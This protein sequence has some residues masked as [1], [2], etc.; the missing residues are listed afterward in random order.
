MKKMLLLV[1][2]VFIFF[3]RGESAFG[4]ASLY[5]TPPGKIRQG[6]KNP[7][8]LGEKCS[9]LTQRQKQSGQ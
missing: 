2:F 4:G 5:Y 1:F 6:V 8:F 9:V 3:A 7:S